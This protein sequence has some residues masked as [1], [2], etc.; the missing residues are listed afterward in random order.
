MKGFNWATYPLSR[1][2]QER[3]TDVL[4]T[5]KSQKPYVFLLRN[6]FVRSNELFFVYDTPPSAPMLLAR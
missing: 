3:K 5:Y 2:V 6:A 1:L 4:M